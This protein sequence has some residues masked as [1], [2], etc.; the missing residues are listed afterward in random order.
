MLLWS[1]LVWAVCEGCSAMPAA[2]DKEQKSERQ[3]DT[4][5]VALN[6]GF[7]CF[8]LPRLVIGAMHQLETKKHKSSSY[9]KTNFAHG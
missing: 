1:E 2:Q 9:K 5:L 3:P 6:C 8:L 7:L 4:C